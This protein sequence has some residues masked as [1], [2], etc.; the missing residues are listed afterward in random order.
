MNNEYGTLT[1]YFIPSPYGLDWTNPTTLA[2]TIVKNKVLPGSRFMG[3]VNIELKYTTSAGEDVDI[4]TG[5][6]AK[7]MNAPELLFKKKMGMGIL[8][9]SF[10]G[11]L[12]TKEELVPELSKYF[13]IG[14][15]KINFATFKLNIDVC[16]RISEYLAK[17]AQN[18]HHKYYGLYNRPLHGEGGGCSAFGASF[19]EVA[20]ILDDEH[21][22]HWT[23]TYKVPKHLVGGENSEHSPNFL[24]IYLQNHTWANEGD[25]HHMIFFWDPDKMHAWVE[26]KIKDFNHGPSDYSLD[27]IENSTGIVF[28]YTHV[29]KPNDEIFKH[30]NGEE[31]P[32]IRPEPPK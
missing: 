31:I 23:H 32:S 4:L 15:K 2:R 3:H 9:H 27:K 22:E 21:R 25:P 29:E 11:H 10:D 28:D 5:M 18:E 14:N 26:N 20:G 24:K 7:K 17:Y 13:K 12:E 1:L 6:R 8:Y 16:E 19:L 30:G